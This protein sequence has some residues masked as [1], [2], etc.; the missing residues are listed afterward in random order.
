MK[1]KDLILGLI[2]A[3]VFLLFAV[4]GTKLIYDWPDYNDY[5]GKDLRTPEAVKIPAGSADDC[6]EII[7]LDVISQQC[8][9][10][11]GFLRYEYDQNGCIQDV[12][13]DFC[14]RD[15]NDANETYSKNLFI[16]SLVLSLIV[17][18]VS[19]LF[20]HVESVSGGLMLG[21]LMYLVYGTGRY[22]QYMDDILRFLILGIALGILIYV[23]YYLAKK[24]SKKDSNKK[25]K[26]EDDKKVR[27]SKGK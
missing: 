25:D 3:V 19:V 2:I 4:Y 16:I 6:T 13:C 1:V 12:E 20:V 9:D 11:D 27:K 17:I 15:Y 26:S 8:Y 5:C 24:Q 21:S 14:A 10:Q 18:V 22:W 23:G 7:N